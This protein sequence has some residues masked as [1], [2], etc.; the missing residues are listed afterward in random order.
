MRINYTNGYYEGSVDGNDEP[1]GFGFLN[2]DEYTYEGYYSHG[3][4]HGCGKMSWPDGSHFEGEFKDGQL[5]T[6]CGYIK[7]DDGVIYDGEYRNGELNGRGKKVWP[8]GSHFEGEFNDDDFWTG[9]GYI[10]YDDGCTYEGEFDS[11]KRNGQGK[12]AW[13]DGSHFEGTFSDGKRVTG[14]G[15]IKY[16]NGTWFEGSF[17]FG[18]FKFGK[19]YYKWDNGSHFEGEFK[20]GKYWN[21][22]GLIK[23]ASGGWF[24]GTFQ[25]G[26]KDTGKGF[27]QY[28]DGATYEGDFRDGKRNGH[29]RYT[30]KSGGATYEGEWSNDRAYGRGVL[31][32]GGTV[33][34]SGVFD[35]WN[36]A[37]VIKTTT[38]E[39]L[40]MPG[41]LVDMKFIADGLPKVTEGE[42]VTAKK[43]EYAGYSYDL[44]GY[45]IT[46]FE[47]KKVYIKD[48]FFSFSLDNQEEMK[49]GNAPIGADGRSVELHHTTQRDD[50]PIVEILYTVHKGYYSTLHDTAQNEYGSDIDRAAF[51]AW[52]KRYWK[53]RVEE[54]LKNH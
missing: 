23:T 11:G 4:E 32:L 8:D 12:M 31:T 39:R 48:G 2:V 18:K 5:W 9:R 3:K 24:E 54:Y 21:G 51:T 20:D 34:Y 6:G 30:F 35:G 19:G 41:K 16:T 44:G 38:T 7:Y 33:T 1:D 25:S 13:P 52:K 45:K 46:E 27:I 26:V 29:G 15:Y 40:G 47:G 10:K 50:S 43:S 22:K 49:K 53:H 14:S 36:A 17:E 28:Q 37:S 42:R